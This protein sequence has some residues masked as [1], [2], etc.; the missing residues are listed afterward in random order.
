MISCFR[1][2]SFQKLKISRLIE[3]RPFKLDR[4]ARFLIGILQDFKIFKLQD[5]K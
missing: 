5:P 2:S 3:F 4:I 1:I